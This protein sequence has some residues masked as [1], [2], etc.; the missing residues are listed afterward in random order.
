MNLKTEG[1]D[2]T[3]PRGQ[4]YLHQA[5]FSN[6]SEKNREKKNIM[7]PISD[8]RI[9]TRKGS[10]TCVNNGKGVNHS[11]KVQPE[12]ID[13]AKPPNSIAYLTSRNHSGNQFFF[14][15]NEAKS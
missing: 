9:P 1:N 8:Q 7:K 15:L 12:N 5:R 2:S 13:I 14:L 3:A 4:I 6:K 10:R 11:R